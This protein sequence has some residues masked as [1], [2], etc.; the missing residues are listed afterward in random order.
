M[1]HKGMFRICAVEC[2]T[3]LCTET[4][5]HLRPDTIKNWCKM[6]G[7]RPETSRAKVFFEVALQLIELM[8]C[9]L[10]EVHMGSEFLAESCN[11]ELYKT[12][13]SHTPFSESGFAAH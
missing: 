2:L 13:A 5:G 4:C 10:Q 3:Q 11:L 1:K 9:I 12:L 8:K 7:V 6:A